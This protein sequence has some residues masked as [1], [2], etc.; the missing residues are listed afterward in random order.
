[1]PTSAS[2]P[3]GPGAGGAGATG[4]AGGRG[5]DGA[6]GGSG[7]G[8]DGGQGGQRP[9]VCTPSPDNITGPYYR[10]NAPFRTDLTEPGMAGTR[11]TVSGRVL[12]PACQPIA[13][14]LIDVWQA[15]DDGGYDND[16]VDDPPA[17]D[18]VLRGRMAADGDGAYSFRTIIPGHYLN[19]AEF[20]PAHLHVTV[21]APG[22]F[23]L[24]TQLYFE[25]DPY[26]AADPWYLAALEL[27]LEDAGQEK[28]STFDF[29][30]EPA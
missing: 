25:G 6:L 22:F 24:T 10:Q 2:G 23:S 8:G 3:T 13:G 14:A 7:A 4:G 9:L 5:G 11:I 28:T 30:L 18:Y 19:G 20:R 15:D 16:G 12:D 21:S 29:V 26:N 1:M 17:S 27:A